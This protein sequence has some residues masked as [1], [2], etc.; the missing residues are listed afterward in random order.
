M[1]HEDLMS[2]IKR[3]EIKKEIISDC[4]GSIYFLHNN[5]NEE[6]K[7]CF[8]ENKFKVKRLKQ[9]NDDLTEKEFLSCLKKLAGVGSGKMRY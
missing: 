8:K 1:T 2:T 7:F 3:K 4:E 9:G 6:H 5:P